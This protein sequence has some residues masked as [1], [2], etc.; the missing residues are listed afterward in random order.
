MVVVPASFSFDAPA[1]LWVLLLL[2]G[3]AVAAV[4]LRVRRRRDAEAYAS[5]EL[6]GSVASRLSPWPRRLGVLGFAL[7]T[8]V[9]TTGFARPSIEAKVGRDHAVVMIAL[10]TSTSMQVDDVK[11]NRFEAAKATAQEFIRGLPDTVDVGLVGYNA[12]AT[13]VAAPTSD[14]EAVARAVD[15]LT[16]KGGTA[17]GDALS[18]SLE[19]ALRDLQD[20]GSAPDT[21][22]APAARLVL[23]SDGG[24]TAGSPLQEA[25]TA[26]ADAQV[27]VSTI[28]LGTES[29]EGKV[30]DGRS[31][32]APVD[33]TALQSV[34]DGTGGT[35]YRAAASAQLSEIY[36]DIGAEVVTRTE[37]K[38]IS[39]TFAGVGL[40]L[41]ALV[42]VPT[43]VW[44]GRLL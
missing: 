35:A 30:F 11:P 41:L 38:D 42:A 31:V 16:M 18:L 33:Y 3:L 28:A 14:H 19:S 29:G 22:R 39:T 5:A 10:D 37:R 12:T 36:D 27:P 4:T 21:G 43:L 20:D 26:A 8:L 9:L 23:L 24:N 1:R 13:L 34:A 15:T 6:R 32:Q 17:M 7:A 25:V 44:S 40:A 2:A